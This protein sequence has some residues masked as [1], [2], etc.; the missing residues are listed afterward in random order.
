MKLSKLLFGSLVL[1]V[2]FA[3]CT[4]EDLMETLPSTPESVLEQAVSL[5]EDFSIVGQ[6]S[7]AQTRFVWDTDLNG[8][9]ETTDTVGGAWYAYTTDGGETGNYIGGSYNYY[10]NHPFAYVKALA[11]GAAEFKAPTNA[12]AG[13]YVLYYPYNFKVTNV[14]TVIPVEFDQNPVMDCT[15]GKEMDHV[16]AN[17]F[18]WCDAEFAVGGPQAGEFK[19]NQ[20]GNLIVLNI[21][22]TEGNIDRIQN[23]EISKVILESTGKLVAKGKITPKAGLTYEKM[24]AEYAADGNVSTYILTPENATADYQVTA[25]GETGV[26]KKPFYISMLPADKSI[27]ELTVRVILKDGRVY[28]KEFTKADDADLFDKLV[29]SAQKIELE[30]L[31]DT[32]DDANGVYTVEQFNEALNSGKTDIELAADI[33]LPSLSFNKSGKT[34]TVTGSNLTIAGA[35]NVTEGTLIINSGFT[36]KGNVTVSEYG[37]LQATNV[38]EMAAVKVDG[39]ATLTATEEDVEIA[40]VE[41]TK[42]SILSL[43]NV[44]TGKATFGRSA[45][46]TLDGVTLKGKTSSTDADITIA[47]NAVTNKST[48]SATD[49]SI[50]AVKA[51]N[52]EGTMTLS[53]VTVS[54]NE[55]I[56]NGNGATLTIAGDDATL[57]KVTNAA[58]ISTPTAKAAGIVNVELDE[59]DAELTFAGLTQNGVMYVKKG[60]IKESAQNAFGFGATSITNVAAD[61]VVTLNTSSSAVGTSGAKMVIVSTTNITSEDKTK[62]TNVSVA[63]EI[64]NANKLAETVSGMNTLVDEFIINAANAT[65][66]ATSATT[67]VTKTLTLKQNVKLGADMTMTKALNVEGDVTI[68]ADAAQTIE[69]AA[70]PIENTINGKLTVGK[71]VTLQGNASGSTI[72]LVDGSTVKEG[73]EGTYDPTNINYT[74]E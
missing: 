51:L 23:K 70:T 43:T 25:A 7:G 42:A 61:G 2:P 39:E 72:V 33:E 21:G 56:A 48:F 6:K 47:N 3:A 8:E 36:T 10:S 68:T 17:F 16:N 35:L 18:A 1:A 15:S 11:D 57:S 37:T 12:M 20:A 62:L 31:L 34:V 67:L 24:V 32:E 52:N 14:S 4:N 69:L 29:K 63:T 53:T 66:D 55:G 40:S 49:G 26:T 28:K 22:S 74:L 13:K 58:A 59:A 30:A 60:I 46:I 73:T 19:L 9:W 27:A 38:V 71:N 41:A 44:I 50:N 64:T 45:D 54:G 65:I 5:G